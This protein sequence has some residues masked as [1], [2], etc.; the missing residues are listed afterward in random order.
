MEDFLPGPR[1]PL[2]FLASVVAVTGRKHLTTACSHFTGFFGEESRERRLESPR[3][4][5]T[6]G[7]AKRVKRTTTTEVETG[8]TSRRISGALAT[9][10]VRQPPRHW[11]S[12]FIKDRSDVPVCWNVHLDGSIGAPQPREDTP[13]V[14]AG[15]F[16]GVKH[17]DSSRSFGSSSHLASQLKVTLVSQLL[18]RNCVS[19]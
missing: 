11:M 2:L 5:G 10:V 6:G 12:F 17:P 8:E 4:G 1:S 7:R 9:L 18:R 14:R 19:I 3:R 13:P 16:P 15:P